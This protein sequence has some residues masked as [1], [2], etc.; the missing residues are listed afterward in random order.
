MLGWMLGRGD[1]APDAVDGDTTLLDQP[2][3]PAPVFAARSLKSALFGTPIRDA[4]RSSRDRKTAKSISVAAEHGLD[5]PLKPPPQGILLTPGTGTSRPKRVSFNHELATTK[6]ISP[7]NEGAAVGKRTRLSDV[8]EKA[9]RK[10]TTN[11]SKTTTPQIV[12]DESDEEDWEEEEHNDVGDY[13]ANDV[14]LDL[15][16][17]R[18][19]SGIYWKEEF[20]KYHREARAEMEKLLKY[21]KHL[22]SY[23]EEK[24]LEALQLSQKLKEEQEKVAAMEKKLAES[25]SQMA[26]KR[27]GETAEI[28]TTLADSN[29]LVAQLRRRIRELEAG[30]PEEREEDD[31]AREWRRLQGATSPNTA[32]TLLETQREL[33]RSR[34]QMKELDALRGQVSSLKAQ[35]KVAEQRKATDHLASDDVSDT[36]KMKELKAQLRQAKEDSARKDAEFAQLKQDFDLFR[37]ESS[38]HEADTKAVLERAQTKISD[39]K[40]ELKTLKNKDTADEARPRGRNHTSGGSKV[41]RDSED[42]DVLPRLHAVANG[43]RRSIDVADLERPRHL[44][45]GSKL[46][47]RNLRDKYQTDA[48]PGQSR[49]TAKSRGAGEASGDRPNTEKSKWPSFA[50]RPPR[51]RASVSE[52]APVGSEEDDTA[53]LPSISTVVKTAGQAKKSASLEDDTDVQ[54]DLLQDRFV[55]LGGPEAAQDKLKDVSKTSNMKG[56]LPPERRAAALARIEKRMA[57]KRAK[58]RDGLDK[59]NDEIETEIALLERRLHEAKA[60]LSALNSS[61]SAPASIAFHPLPSASSSTHFLLLLAD[62]ALPIGSFA[63]SSGLE[64]FAAHNRPRAAAS[65]DAFLPLSLSSHASSTLPFV[66]AAHR[67]PQALAALDDQLDAAVVCTVGRRASVAQGRALLSIWERSFKAALLPSSSTNTSNTSNT[68]NTGSGGSGISPDALV[69]SDF[70]ALLRRESTKSGTDPP[71]VSA[72]LGPLFGVVAAVVGLSLRQTAYV[73]MLSHVKALVSAAV[74]ANMF[75]PYQA[76]KLLASEHVQ[77]LINA[78][79]ERE[80]HTS[81]EEAGQSVPVMDLWVGRHELLYSRIFNS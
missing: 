75:G 74:R 79:V 40:K 31:E 3:T 57:E 10:S 5:T 34:A 16:E 43:T 70:S 72:H 18:S 48:T 56:L 28:P 80:W 65:F 53:P 71:L 61:S 11:V 52:A 4:Q 6:T 55:R 35:L 36:A 66:L 27:K 1:N 14:T 30:V 58:R 2:D 12:K 21:K 13:G 7:N 64:S 8:L 9:R 33:R 38:A 32:R 54:V 67:R 20:E 69:L 42:E 78:V 17:P 15:N 39:L 23:A 59:E 29:A 77:A 51:D 49:A 73:F 50:P 25:A 60:R 24:D 41:P 26:S 37:K 81:V 44:F 63:F 45:E 47:S 46:K 68:S 62:S 76:Q 22:K 19:Q